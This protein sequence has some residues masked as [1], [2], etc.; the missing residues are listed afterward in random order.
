MT[1][2]GSTF[3]TAAALEAAGLIP[4]DRVAALE[5][6]AAAYAVAVTPALAALIV[7]PE[8]ALFL[9]RLIA[10]ELLK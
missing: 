6:V 9:P 7:W 8:I 1:M 5:P 10:P 3:R 2:R 4:A